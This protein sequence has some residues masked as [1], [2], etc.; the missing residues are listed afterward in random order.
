MSLL[1]LHCRS[2][3]RF[4]RILFAGIRRQELV[5]QRTANRRPPEDHP[6]G[7]M[8]RFRFRHGPVAVQRS[9]ELGTRR[10][11]FGVRVGRSRGTDLRPGQ[12]QNEYNVRRLGDPP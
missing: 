9:I 1:K 7:N 2:R 6:A 11:H 5:P 3:V 4:D 10:F 12:R 8:V